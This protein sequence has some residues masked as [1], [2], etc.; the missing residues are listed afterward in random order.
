[1]GVNSFSC[2]NPFRSRKYTKL[3]MFYKFGQGLVKFRYSEKA[4][5]ICPI[6]HLE[7]DAIRFCQIKSGRLEKNCGLLRIS[8]LILALLPLQALRP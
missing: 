7:F 6:F 3:I 5:K 1:M 8:E 2:C 4:P